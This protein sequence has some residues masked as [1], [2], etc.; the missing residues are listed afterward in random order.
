MAWEGKYFLRYGLRAV[1]VQY[2]W[3]PSAMFSG[4]ENARSVLDGTVLQYESEARDM[5]SS[6][7]P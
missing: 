7:I 5:D 2:A 3:A 4:S 6:G 1:S